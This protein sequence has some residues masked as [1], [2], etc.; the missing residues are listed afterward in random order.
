MR[1]IFSRKGVDSSAGGLASPILDGSLVSLPIPSSDRPIT[2]GDLVFGRVSLGK[3][4]EDLSNGTIKSNRNVHLDPDILHGLYPRQ[5]GWRPIFGQGQ[6]AAESHLQSC[7]VTVGDLFLF[8]GWFREAELK[9]GR[10]RY[11]RGAL[12]LHVLYGW[13]QVGAVI[14]C[15]DRQL[16][17]IPWAR[18]HPHFRNRYGTAYIARNK[19]DLGANSHEIPGGGQFSRF[20]NCLRLTAPNSASRRQWQLPGW[21]YPRNGCLPLTYHPNKSSFRRSGR[22]TI[23]ESAGRG[24]E[25]VLDSRDYPEAI[26]WAR[27]LITTSITAGGE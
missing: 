5:P 1:I 16:S 12:N 14:P 17:D 27:R 21:F 19:L 23:V 24:Q 8:F 9:D 26:Q 10:Y 25:F 20:H 7:G 18:Y 4:V 11:R 6:P 15:N 3:V 13:L 2:Y 22:Y